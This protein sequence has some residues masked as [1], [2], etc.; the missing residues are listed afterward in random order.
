VLCCAG[1]SNDCGRVQRVGASSPLFREKELCIEGRSDAGQRAQWQA[2][3]SVL[4]LGFR[5]AEHLTGAGWRPPSNSP[6]RVS[7]PTASPSVVEP[8]TVNNWRT[9]RFSENNPKYY[10]RR[11]YFPV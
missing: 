2:A 3:P 8:N 6:T 1:Y 7:L 10:A 5:E 11:E 9:L 4:R